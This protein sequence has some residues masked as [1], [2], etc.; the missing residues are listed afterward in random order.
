[1]NHYLPYCGLKCLNQKEIN[2]FDVNSICKYNS[3]E[4]VLEVDLRYPDELHE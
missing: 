2:K 1:M 4:H 3:I